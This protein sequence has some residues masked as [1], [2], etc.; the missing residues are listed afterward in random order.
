MVV[1]ESGQRH[2]FMEGILTGVMARQKEV[3]GRKESCR[4][5]YDNPTQNNRKGEVVARQYSA[6]KIPC[7][8]SGL[9]RTE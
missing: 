2:S 4:L 3:G 9:H 5:V 1:S 6:V 7:A 8:E